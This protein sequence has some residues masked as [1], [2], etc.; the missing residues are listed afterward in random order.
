MQKA[1]QKMQKANTKRQKADQKG[2]KDQKMQKAGRK[3]QKAN[4][5]RLF[6]KC[7]EKTT[8]FATPWGF[9][10]FLVPSQCCFGR[11]F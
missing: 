6:E 10:I 11:L 8:V 5:V 4:I 2:K 9:A 7:M 3:I 1:N